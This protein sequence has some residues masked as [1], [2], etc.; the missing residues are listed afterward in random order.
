M[1][2]AAPW[3][4]P[5]SNDLG[6]NSVLPTTRTRS[7][8][9][10]ESFRCLC[11]H[12]EAG[13]W[14]KCTQMFT[15]VIGFPRNYYTVIDWVRGQQQFCLT[16]SRRLR[17]TDPF[18]GQ[19]KLLLSEEPVYNCFVIH[20]H[21][22]VN[23]TWLIEPMKIRPSVNSSIAGNRSMNCWPV[24]RTVLQL[25]GILL[26]TAKNVVFLFYWFYIWEKMMVYNNKYYQRVESP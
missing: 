15:V 22:D 20:R 8:T 4:N 1:K 25:V 9:S 6:Y 11:R 17:A 5:W 10:K 14:H 19:T 18:S 16:R 3:W 13:T 26:L 2:I 7:V 21:C 24:N 23:M 12:L